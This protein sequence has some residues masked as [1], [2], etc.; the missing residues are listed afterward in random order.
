MGVYPSQTN[1]T[2]QTN[3]T[4]LVHLVGSRLFFPESQA[5]FDLMGSLMRNSTCPAPTD[6][7]VAPRLRNITALCAVADPAA[8]DGALVGGVRLR[9]EGEDADEGP[10]CV[11]YPVQGE[12]VD[13]T[14]L[15]GVADHAAGLYGPGTY[16]F[17]FSGFRTEEFRY[18][19]WSVQFLQLPPQDGG[20]DVDAGAV[21]RANVTSK[22]AF[23][24]NPIW[25]PKPMLVNAF[26]IAAIV[27]CAIFFVSSGLR[28]D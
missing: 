3:E 25:P 16:H 1:L 17:N 21:L 2:L 22:G 28:M 27:A 20:D 9:G 26:F 12:I 19:F 6:E 10:L 4:V 15:A 23:V 18:A 14:G 5:F 7:D 13:A 8:D 11:I 24:N